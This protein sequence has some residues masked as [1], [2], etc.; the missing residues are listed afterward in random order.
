M[1]VAQDQQRN[2]DSVRVANRTSFH[3]GETTID[4]GA[5]YN[6]RHVKHPI[7]QWLD[8]TVDDYGAFIRAVDDRSFDGFRNRLIVGTNIQN[9]TI[10]T[11]Q[12]V[13]LPGAVKGALAASMADKSRNLSLY[14]EDSLFVTPG[15]AL[16]AGVQYLHASRNRHDRFLLDGNQSGQRNHDLWSP[17]FGILW[18]A[19][20]D[21]QFFA[22]VSRSAEIASYDANI[23]A[24]PS[25]NLAAQRATT[26]EIGTR[27]RGGGIGWDVALYRAEIRNELQCLTTGP[28]SACSIINAD[29]TVHQG[30]EAG[31]DADVP[32]STTGDALSFTAAY[33]YNDFFFDGDALYGNNR[34]PGVPEHYLR[35]EM[36]YKHPS[37][38][39]AGPNVEW[40]PRRYYAD[41]ANSLTVDRYALLNLKAGLDLGKWSAYVEGRNLTDKQYISTVAVAGTANADD[42]LF[43]PGTGRAIHAGVRVQW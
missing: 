9:G 18:D 34:L 16:I 3:F 14:A 37:G 2:V 42:E 28:F 8:F 39:Y 31:L 30:V 29:R 4:L 13:N 43:N 1:W 33:T 38:F 22:N 25:T 15:L 32:L 11:E 17:R 5:F 21:I 36:L 27:G 24:T 20:S 23:F 6:N 12:F 7:F 35:A 41:N 40:S 19:A 10:D 26:Y